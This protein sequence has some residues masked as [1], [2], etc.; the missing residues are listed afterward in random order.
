LEISVRVSEKECSGY[1]LKDHGKQEALMSPTV[2]VFTSCYNQGS[3]LKKAALSVLGQTFKDFEYLMYDDG[4][5]DSTWEVMQ[6]MSKVDPRIKAVK[7]D[8]Q[9]NV[10]C[11]INRSLQDY[12]GKYWIWLPSDD[13]LEPACLEKKL[14]YVKKY[15]NSVLYSEWYQIDGSDNVTIERK[16][17]N[18]TPDE[19]SKV[20]W[21]R[22]PIGF[23]G[24]LIPRGVF[25]V[26]G[27]FPT[28]LK[29]SEDYYWMI[30]A[31]IHGVPFRGVPEKLYRKR[32]H[33]NRL[34][35]QHQHDIPK[36]VESI[37]SELRMYRESLNR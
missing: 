31:T 18:L 10:G 8:K 3:Y 1:G 22:C 20:I 35:S 4:S 32:V 21:E 26:V 24:V 15:G 36:L 29:C 11:V 25:N 2:S 12:T 30:K 5:T 9:K 6:E 23:T 16:P 19:F 27:P 13:L 37:R 34:S 28:H 17:E 33:Q 14:E 7:L